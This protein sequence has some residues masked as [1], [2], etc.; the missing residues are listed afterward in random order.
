MTP[1]YDIVIIGLSVTS[2]WGNGHA[3][4]YRSLIRA[5]KAR[6]HRVL[7]LENDVPWYSQNRD[8][9]HPPGAVTELYYGFEDLVARFESAVQKAPLVIV[10]SFV[11]DGSRVGEWVNSIAQG[12]TAFYDIDTPVTLD[13]LEHG[14]RRY[15]TP[16]LMR[17]YDAYFS[18]TGGPMLKHLES[19][20][21]VRM[22]RPLYCSVDPEMYQPLPA[23]ISWDFGYLGTY[24][25]DRQEALE[26]LLLEPARRYPGGRFT[27]VGAMYPDS[28]E[29]PE[30]VATKTHLAPPEHSA[31]YNSQRFT[32]NITRGEMKQAG[33][34]PS[35]RLFEAGACGV[36]VISDW[37]EGLDEIFDI[38]KEVLISEGPED[39]LR[40]L[41][42]IAEP[43]RLAMGE[44]ARR[45]VLS[46]H[47]ATHRAIQLEQY[48]REM[49]D[50]AAIDPPRANGRYRSLDHG[51][52]AGAPSQ[53]GRPGS[54]AG[55]GAENGASANSS[56][57]F[58]PARTS[59][60]DGAA[61]RYKAR[62]GATAVE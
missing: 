12:R 52:A 59:A 35:I 41:H 60:R 7:F 42:D 16:S 28:I 26:S 51:V 46:G 20:Y 53:S 55:S 4:T 30:N 48:L 15:I 27:V 13:H 40:Y 49:N 9:P 32:L 36:P 3:T 38:G 5:L 8:A 56:H 39:T 25:R 17:R 58:Q 10:G 33:Y 22:A 54:G 43:Q 61:D 29:W 24:S 21:G 44:A 19:H 1:P 11:V 14:E 2:S 34:S 57:L 62:I 50:N 45:R 37:W 23:A 18:F 31:F 6:G 47:T